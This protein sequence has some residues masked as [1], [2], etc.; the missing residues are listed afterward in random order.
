MWILKVNDTLIHIVKHYMLI[1]FAVTAL[2]M[3]QN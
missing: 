3:L 1:L 2:N